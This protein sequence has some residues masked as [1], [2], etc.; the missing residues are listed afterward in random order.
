MARETKAERLAREAT[1]REAMLE[2]QGA[3]Y[4]S[5]LMTLMQRAQKANFEL[6]VV[7]QMFELRE[8]DERDPTTVQ[9][10][11]VYSTYA[12]AMLERFTWDVDYKEEAEKEAKRKFLAK[13][14]VLAKL[15]KEEQALLGLV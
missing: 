9:L 13:Q 15:S 14:V 5:R 10:D 3:T 4:L 2:E 6:T 12:E 1:V 11:P 7:D 8:R